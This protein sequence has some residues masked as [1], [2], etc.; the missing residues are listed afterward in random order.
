LSFFRLIR[1]L[2]AAFC[3]AVLALCTAWVLPSLAAAMEAALAARSEQVAGVVAQDFA[4]AVLP[5]AQPLSAWLP[6]LKERARQETWAQFR[7]E[8][9]QGAVM[10]EQPLA[11][12]GWQ[13]LLTQAWSGASSRVAL[14]R[15]GQVQGQLVLTVATQAATQQLTR[16]ALGLL[17]ALAVLTGLALWAL[18]RLYRWGLQPLAKFCEQIEALGERRFVSVP[19]PG[20]SEWVLLSKLLNVLVAR[21]RQILEERDQELGHLEDK[22]SHDALTHTA[23][24]ETFM[25]AL[26]SQLKDNEAGGGVAIVRVH[27]LDGLNRRLGRNRADEFLVAVA[28]TLRAR[29]MID[30]DGDGEGEGS[31]LARLNGADFGLLQPGCD[32]AAWRARLASVGDA[33]S[34]LA[35]EGLTD[36]SQVA[37]VGGS[38][39]KRGEA[40]SDVLTRVD[41]MVMAAETRQE[42]VRV[43]EPSAL[44]HVLAMAQ[45]RVVIETALDTGHLE[46][47]FTPVLDARGQL[48]YR[49]AHLALLDPSGLRL[50]DDDFVPAAVRCGRSTDVDLKAVGLALAELGRSPGSVAVRVAPQSVLRPIFQRQLSEL[51]AAHAPLAPRLCLQVRQLGVG[52][53]GA[54]EILS[55]T[56]VPH[57]CAVGVEQVG[58][59][60]GALP[61]LGSAGVRYLT[62]APEIASA[63][64]S[65]TRL[66]TLVQLLAQW[67]ERTAV[68][69]VATEVDSLALAAELRAMG[70]RGF[71]GVAMAPGQALPDLALASR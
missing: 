55:R 7:V 3:L 22:L 33:L 1:A 56:V 26:K 65:N 49:E 36:G 43:T 41:T 48:I 66:Q 63:A 42:Q 8:S 12:R 32:L 35:E 54:V 68:T 5:D 18:Q 19:Q 44:Q 57:G 60:L 37:W 53:T 64:V 39:Y 21:V 17:L 46:L 9:P 28:T 27:D 71:A 14:V 38:T 31:V 70:V 29:M 69:I 6:V 13:T 45:W 59:W 50:L 23:S 24:R 51:L 34:R 20:V 11:G 15:N 61:L 16:A 25:A 10:A 67:G 52:A 47:G 30:G 62:L 4:R 40:F 58:R 2:L